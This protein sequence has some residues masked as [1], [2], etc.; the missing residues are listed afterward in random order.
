MLQYAFP[1]LTMLIWSANTVVNKMAASSIQP[2]EIGF[3]RWALAGMLFT[4]F[5]LAPVW[6]NRQAIRP[7]AGKIVVLG[8]L[9]MAINQSLAYYA[10]HMTT[11]TNMGIIL[12]LMPLMALALSLLMLGQRLTAG[13]L[14][15]AL[16]SLVGVLIVVSAGNMGALLAHGI[17]TGDAMMLLATL[18]YGVYSVLL[19]KWQLKLPALH[20]LYLQI[21]VAV[22]A[23]LP[24]YLASARTGLNTDN[25]PLVLFA[26]IPTSMLAPLLWMQGIARIGPSRSI[27]F[28]NLLPVLTAL[29]AAV[30]L[31]EQLAGYHVVGG[32][33]VLAGVVLAEVWTRPLGLAFGYEAY[34]KLKPFLPQ[35]PLKN[36]EK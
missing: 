6:R 34:E 31:S 4:P 19:K 11:A 32:V 28:F 23:L 13:A 36:T 26:G 2:A 18:T 30:V 12:S 22:L 35:N 33:L 16:V 20:L 24:L 5:M 25:I 8:V 29:M 10:A 3:Y 27:M 15:G 1:L 9:G 14:L 17:G 21:V 7:Y